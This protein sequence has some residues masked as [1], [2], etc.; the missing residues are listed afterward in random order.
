VLAAVAVFGAA[1]AGGVLL[2]AGPSGATDQGTHLT[3]S[4]GRAATG[5][6]PGAKITV[7]GTGVVSGTPNELIL[8]MGASTTASTATVALDR[9]NVELAALAAVF[10]AAGVPATDI[11]TSGLSLQANYDSS[12]NVTGYQASDDLTV[13]MEDMANAGAVIDAAAHAVGNDVQID[14]ISFS[15]SDM[16]ALLTVART[17][18]VRAAEAKASTFALAAGTT[19]GPVVSISDEEQPSTPIL[20]PSNFA[21]KA[22]AGASAPVPVEAGS[23]QVS[24]QVTVVYELM[25]GHS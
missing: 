7:T 9:N 18:A 6:A 20:E 5:T 4:A 13:T 3:A 21:S 19:L 11:Q 22:A 24:V 25:S 17:R 1:V 15:I 23:E 12:N 16:S 14:G 2:A 10:K 8:Q